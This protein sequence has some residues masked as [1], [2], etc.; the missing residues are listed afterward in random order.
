MK[1]TSLFICAI[2]ISVGVYSQINVKLVNRGAQSIPLFVPGIMNPNLSP[3]SESNLT[4]P[5]GQEVFFGS[6]RK[7]DKCLVFIVD[8]DWPKDTII[9]LTKSELERQCGPVQKPK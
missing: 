8:N 7:R 3:F 6:K 9:Y 5:I 2:L 4:F 1:V